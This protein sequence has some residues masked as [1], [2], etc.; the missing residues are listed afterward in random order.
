[1]AI[2]SVAR[3]V[4]IAGKDNVQWGEH[5]CA[6]FN[7]RID[8]LNL[9]VPYIKAGLEDNEFCLWITDEN[10]EQQAM[11]ALQQV[12]PDAPQR[13]SRKQLEI[14]P[15]SEW[16]LSAGVF[17]AGKSFRNWAARGRL[18]EANRFVGA[19]TTG[20][21]F[22]LQSNEDW[23]QFLMYEQAVHQ[24]IETQR[25]ISLCT[26]PVGICSAKDMIGTFASHHAVLMHQGGTW[27]DA[28][29]CLT[30]RDRRGFA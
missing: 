21:P 11:E 16:Y 22:W 24:A 4:G 19:R 3:R 17:D 26:Y 14:L 8:L 27:G 18:A 28:W 30:L 12:L 15:A 13:V 5:L 25:V 7:T 20:T 10:M 1:M 23:R 9:V 2:G 29:Q 6:F